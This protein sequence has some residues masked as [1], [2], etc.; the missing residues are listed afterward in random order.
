MR[1]SLIDC[2]K[3][4]AEMNTLGSRELLSA[5]YSSVYKLLRGGF[6]QSEVF[7]VV[8]V[9]GYTLGAECANNQAA[10]S[11]EYHRETTQKRSDISFLSWIEMYRV[12]LIKAVIGYIIKLAQ[13]E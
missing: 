13:F 7:R 12:V 11:V 2:L 10:A 4:L 8:D 5:T 9:H 3:M 1:L 6:V